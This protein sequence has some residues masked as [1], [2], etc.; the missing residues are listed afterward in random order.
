MDMHILVLKYSGQGPIV[1][2]FSKICYSIARGGIIDFFPADYNFDCIMKG[3]RIKKNDEEYLEFGK[4]FLRLNLGK[5]TIHLGNL[6]A[7][8]PILARATNDVISDNTDVFINEIKPVLESTL[9]S[10]FTEIAN[11]ITTTF[12]YKELFPLS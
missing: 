4:M 8:D 10:K 12:T 1:G 11:K 9:A 2:N 5:S 7:Q 6:F 3:N